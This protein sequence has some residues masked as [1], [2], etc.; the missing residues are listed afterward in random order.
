MHGEKVVEQQASTYY[1]T[2]E[3]AGRYHGMRIAIPAE[4]W[5]V[6]HAL[7]PEWMANLLWEWAGFVRLLRCPKSKRGLKKPLPSVSTIPTNRMSPPRGCSP[8]AGDSDSSLEPLTAKKALDGPGV[9]NQPGGP[10]RCENSFVTLILAVDQP[11]QPTLYHLR[12][13]D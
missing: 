9:G 3:I 11:A 10:G 7:G 4:E 6:F 13:E 5:E 1:L 2:N 12:A 8:R